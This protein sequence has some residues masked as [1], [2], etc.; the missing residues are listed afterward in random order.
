MNI[1]RLDIFVRSENACDLIQ[2]GHGGIIVPFGD[3]ILPIESSVKE[4]QPFWDYSPD[5]LRTLTLAEWNMWAHQRWVYICIDVS[6][7]HCMGHGARKC[8][9]LV[10]VSDL[11]SSI[12]VHDILKLAQR[13]PCYPR[14]LNYTFSI[15][16]VSEC[17]ITTSLDRL[18]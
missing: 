4:F 15:A 17:P 8:L 6:I 14:L 12:S 9:L 18:C 5:K 2:G 3:T 11:H 7:V 10:N 16:N 1:H 13:G